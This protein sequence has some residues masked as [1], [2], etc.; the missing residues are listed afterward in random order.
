[1]TESDRPVQ[2]FL[3]ADLEGV[4]TYEIGEEIWQV[5]L[6]E[7][8]RTEVDAMAEYPVTP[9]HRALGRA[10]LAASLS[11]SMLIALTTIGDTWMSPDGVRYVLAATDPAD[12]LPTPPAS[13]APEPTI[14]EVLR[15][16]PPPIAE[17]GSRR[18]VVRW[19]DGTEAEAFRWYDDEILFSEGDHGNSGPM[20]PRSR[21]PRIERYWGLSWGT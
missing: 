18:A 20:S 13:D 12:E 7:A 16:E 4:P 8:V 5:S 19:S 15:F 9:E 10:T 6:E 1:M 17:S 21:S 2:M 3:S 11:E 14:I